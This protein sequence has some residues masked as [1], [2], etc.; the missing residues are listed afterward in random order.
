MLQEEASCRQLQVA[1]S[2]ERETHQFLVHH[3]GTCCIIQKDDRFQCDNLKGVV[4]AGTETVVT[5]TYKP[6]PLD[7]MLVSN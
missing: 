6:E 7:P 3:A 5:F 2:Q 4:A 1:G